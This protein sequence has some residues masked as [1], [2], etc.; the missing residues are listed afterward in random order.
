MNKYDVIIVGA[1]PAGSSAAFELAGRGFSVLVLDKKS[2]VGNPN[3]CGE[4]I[5]NYCLEE[6]G[7]S[8]DQPWIVNEVLGGRLMFP[9]Q[10]FVTFKQKGYC[11]DRPAFDRFLMNRAV[12]SGCVL[13]TN[14][15]VKK[16]ESIGEGWKISTTEKSFHGTY[17]VGAGGPMCF[18]AHYFM[19]RQQHL[20]AFQY[21]FKI[22]P[23]HQEVVDQRWLDFYHSERF[24]GGYAWVFPRGDEVAIGGGS[25]IKAKER[26]NQFCQD[27]GFNVEKAIRTEGGPIPFLKKPAKICFPN[28]LLVGDAGGFTY[29]LTK[30]G[31]HGAV[32]SGKQAGRVIAHALQENNPRSLAAFESQVK[33]HPCRRSSHL[34]MPQTFFDFD[35]QMFNSIGRI[36]DQLEF[37][38]FPIGR[39]ISELSKFPSPRVLKGFV[40]GGVI[41]YHYRKSKRF[42]W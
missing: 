4:G 18:V 37:S 8:A 27:L 5:S 39:F 1:G 19:Q 13:L 28:A 35:D 15:R 31:I 40:I 41:Q 22:E 9:N 20:P 17:L 2:V 7:V 25:M 24:P 12:D 33:K 36:M 6:V 11:I 3:H 23:S 42:A 29:P 30:G 26:V 10:T 21:K 14:A 34:R 16:I 32:W 38:D